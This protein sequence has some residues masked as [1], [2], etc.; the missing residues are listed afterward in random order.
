MKKIFTALN[1]GYVRHPDKEEEL[2]RNK[3]RSLCDCI[4]VA[5]EA[6][7]MSLFNDKRSSLLWRHVVETTKDL[8]LSFE[9]AEFSL[10]DGKTLLEHCIEAHD[11]DSCF[12]F[13]R[14]L[15]DGAYCDGRVRIK[16]WTLIFD[17]QG[18]EKQLGM[19]A[20]PSGA[21]YAGEMSFGKKNGAG[22]VKSA[23]GDVFFEGTY[24]DNQRHG[25]GIYKTGSDKR[26]SYQGIFEEGRWKGKVSKESPSKR[27]RIMEKFFK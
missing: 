9:V 13:F 2:L 3:P 8:G 25:L 7:Q 11:W 5:K 17:I 1:R 15:P 12:E 6:T 23:S 24:K 10:D 19:Q 21:Y 14:G 4:R 22:M 16:Q 26:F 20:N 18:K 27:S